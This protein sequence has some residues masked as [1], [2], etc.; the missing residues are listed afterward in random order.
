MTDLV[1]FARLG[2][3]RMLKALCAACFP[4]D[5][6]DFW[7]WLFSRVYRPENT[8]VIQRGE[9]LCAAL[10][11]VPCVLGLGKDRFSAHYIYGAAT[12]PCWRGKGLMGQ[13][14]Q[15]AAQEG[16]RRE[17]LFSVL[18]TQEDSLLD[19]YA[20]FGYQNSLMIGVASPQPVLEKTGK[21][22]LASPADILDLDRVYERAADGWMYGVRSPDHW[23][24]QLDLF[25]QGAWVWLE[26]NQITAYAFADER[27]IVEALGA[28]AGQLAAR[29]APQ[30][31]WRTFP[32]KNARPI[33][34]IRPLV[35]QGQRLLENRL[36][37]LNLMYN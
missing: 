12:L 27:G 25:G 19:Y 15:A 11:M 33:G 23:L 36:V 31:P 3:E 24:D 14:L 32:G 17:Q 21:A 20:R 28:G 37:Y 6:M 5:G 34:S 22:R 30:K 1:R 7:D 35:E 9:T 16:Q 4:E 2:E 8:L 10:Q 29:L 18:I 13:L 26:E